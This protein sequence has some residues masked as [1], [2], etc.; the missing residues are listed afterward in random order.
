MNFAE[1]AFTFNAKRHANNACTYMLDHIL[2]P[3]IMFII[4][5]IIVSVF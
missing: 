1:K 3:T 5:I 2:I 4:K